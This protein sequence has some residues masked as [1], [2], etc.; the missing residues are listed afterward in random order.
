MLTDLR[1]NRFKGVKSGKITDL[2]D[3]N[4]FVGPNNAGKSTVLDSI[5]LLSNIFS[6]EDPL[7]NSIP[8]YL[9]SKKGGYPDNNALHYKYNTKKEIGFEFKLKNSNKLINTKFDNELWVINDGFYS[10]ETSDNEDNELR[11]R[12][13]DEKTGNEYNGKSELFSRRN[14]VRGN[15]DLYSDMND[16]FGSSLYFHSGIFEVL[17]QVE[18]EVWENLV[19]DRKDKIVIDHLN[20]VY[21]TEVEQLTFV[22][23]DEGFELRVLFEEYSSRIDS[24][25]DGFRYLFSLISSIESF[26]ANT[27]LVEE[28]E[29]AQHPKTYSN[30]SDILTNYTTVNGLQTFIATHSYEMIDSLLKSCK[31]TETEI[32]IYHLNLE[33][34]TLETRS[35]DSP[36]IEVLEDLGIDPRRLKEYE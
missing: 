17:S 2:S 21:D 9:M 3:V 12:F 20:E 1:I 18:R 15:V 34:G 13:I 22:P 24:L 14:L 33:N 23:V 16:S 31:D 35:I 11:K 29:N 27:I 6:I 30:I 32:S 5:Y 36:D 19:F 28:P 10:F 4:V 25:G 7:G 8:E 26:D